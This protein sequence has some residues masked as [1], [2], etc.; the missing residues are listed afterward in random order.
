M[1]YHRPHEVGPEETVEVSKDVPLV[2]FMPP[3]RCHLQ[4][5]PIATKIYHTATKTT[6]SF[7]TYF[8][9]VSMFKSHFVILRSSVLCNSV[10]V[11]R[12]SI[13][14]RL[15]GGNPCTVSLLPVFLDILMLC[16]MRSYTRYECKL[17]SRRN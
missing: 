12:G 1:W 11:P 17:V 9:Q 2:Y 15:G 16:T 6:P 8:I 10:P 4:G 13:E 7:C 3:E 14:I 5:F